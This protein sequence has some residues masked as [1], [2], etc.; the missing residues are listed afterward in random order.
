MH[1]Q[2]PATPCVCSENENRT[3]LVPKSTRSSSC[4]HCAAIPEARNTG[5]TPCPG[6]RGDVPSRRLLPSMS[7][8]SLTNPSLQASGV[9]RSA[10]TASTHTHSA[11]QP[12]QVLG[13]NPTNAVHPE[14]TSDTPPKH[15]AKKTV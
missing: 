6:A 11:S 5:K 13:I 1:R 4:C 2:P 14:S 7:N 8:S 9:T 10:G 15:P 12:L 3:V